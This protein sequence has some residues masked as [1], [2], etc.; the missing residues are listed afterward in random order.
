VIAVNIGDE[1]EVGFREAGEIRGL[2]WINVDIFAAGFQKH[3]GVVE[4]RQLDIT[5]IGLENRRCRASR[6][7]AG[8]G[9]DAGGEYCERSCNEDSFHGW[10]LQARTAGGSS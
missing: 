7:C 3:R 5:C 8:Y 2:G 1:D 9:A 6:L 4:R 10:L